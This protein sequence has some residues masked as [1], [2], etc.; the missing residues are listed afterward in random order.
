[1]PSKNQNTK[2]QTIVIAI[3][4]IFI[5]YLASFSGILPRFEFQFLDWLWG[6]RP[7]NETINDVVIVGLT[8][9][10]IETLGIPVT[11][12]VLAELINK[13]YQSNP[14]V[15]GLDF[16]RNV[17]VGDED[18]EKLDEV[19]ANN[20]K[21]I[22]VE[23]TNGGNLSFDSI[24]PPIQLEEKGR[25]GGSAAI[26]DF[27]GIVRRAYLYRKKKESLEKTAYY[28]NS[29]AL[30]I[31]LIYLEQLDIFPEKLSKGCVKL[32]QAE[33][34]TLEKINLF[35]PP[36][37]MDDCQIF[38]NYSSDKKTFNQVSFSKVL[39]NK[40]SASLFK[41]K[42]VLIGVNDPA[43]TDKFFIPHP[44]DESRKFIYGVELHGI[45]LN[46][47]INTALNKQKVISFPNII[48]QYFWLVIWLILIAYLSNNLCLDTKN[49]K[50]EIFSVILLLSSS[51]AVL[52]SGYVL[53][54]A[55][56]VMPTITTLC[57]LIFY[58]G[59]TDIVIRFNK[60]RRDKQIL[61]AKVKEKTQAL[62]EAQKIILEQ[63][64]FKV[65][66][67]G[68]YYV[69]HEINNKVHQLDSY[70]SR[71]KKNF[72]KIK[73]FVEESLYLFEED[74]SIP[75]ATN[76]LEDKINNLWQINE[77]IQT[78]I[79]S[80]YQKDEKNLYQI[81]KVVDVNCLLTKIADDLVELKTN[82]IENLVLEVERNYE[83][84]VLQI[85]CV[86]PYIK[87]ALEKI[88]DN[89][90]YQV[91]QKYGEEKNLDYQ[92]KITIIT[93]NQ[94]DSVLIKIKDNGRGI[95]PEDLNK[96]FESFWTTKRIG[97]GLGLGL[98]IAKEI[99][100]L[101]GG[102]ITV[103]SEPGEWAEFT[104]TLPSETK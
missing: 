99:I 74:D 40:F 60:L 46:Q 51:I 23:L 2:W 78:I 77:E 59:I 88:I 11:D 34:A 103:D 68:M 27:D 56:W 18:N 45:I 35:Y 14:T 20:E 19:F 41:N 98:Y 70:L 85:T 64:K 17:D 61:E 7:S 1:M 47:I 38:I 73:F 30:S 72:L 13:I 3:T 101:A 44:I 100:S 39:E 50:A 48:I 96:I 69:A 66:E 102:N 37:E 49:L 29:F 93:R 91:I 83:Q 80:I 6:V 71:A 32:N 33:Y 62:K 31:A 9:K 82:S 84:D 53:F 55:G 65:H 10:D 79:D 86:V 89:S 90:V 76:K 92:P 95:K 57:I 12:K 36:E 54:L 4:S 63:E 16:H 75:K 43:T 52:M 67:I 5:T 15:I 104:I 24:P 8:A 87:R 22:G 58:Q 81:K 42:I 28:I 26:N 94:G 25:T 21:L 97:E